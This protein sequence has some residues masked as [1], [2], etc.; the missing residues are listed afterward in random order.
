MTTG[1]TPSHGVDPTPEINAA[2]NS[3]QPGGA[4]PP[5]ATAPTTPP[6]GAEVQIG[7]ADGAN[8]S[9]YKPEGIPD[10]LLGQDDKGTIDKLFKAY[11]GAR[12]ELAKGKPAPISAADYNFEWSD[13][14]KSAG[15]TNEDPA[16]KAFAEIAEKS[17]FSPEQMA[18]IP[19][20]FDLALEK[21]WI[22]KPFDSGA[23]LTSLA[24]AEYKGS[25]EERQ[26]K[27][28]ERL[29]AAENWIKQLDEN[30]HG[31]SDAMKQE[32]RLLTTSVAGVQVV[33]QLMRS[34]M[35]V[36][37]SPGGGHQPAAATKADLD[38]RISDPRNNF[39]DP[40]FDQQFAEDTRRLF[41][42]LYPE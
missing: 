39:M 20:F 18:A 10:H 38:R 19:K 35:N 33:E 25:T 7:G 13:N 15:L 37:V 24:P 9:A 30:A 3:Q 5:Q 1:D 16:V 4:V 40:K 14:L 8:P 23:L 27:G 29:T 31:F 21:G 42:Q 28:A 36:S 41:K 32:L 11:D 2:D 17:S 22:E 12:T 34:G 6:A 26:T